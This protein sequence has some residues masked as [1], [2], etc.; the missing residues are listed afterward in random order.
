ML[1]SINV[2]PEDKK[3]A[4]VH[5]VPITENGSLVM[6]WDKEEDLL[7]TIGGRLEGD[8][9]IEEALAREAM[10]EVGLII[11]PER[12]P[13]ASWYWESTD[14]YTVWFLVRVHELLPYSFD[15]EKSGHVIFNFETAKHMVP[16][17]EPGVTKRRDL[18]LLAEEKV[19][20]LQLHNV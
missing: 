7:T 12:I 19:K 4:G 10:E 13:F 3:T 9:S 8:E 20:E 11:G 14:S 15:F 17:L 16:K 1:K 18:L 5:C 6:A 2:L